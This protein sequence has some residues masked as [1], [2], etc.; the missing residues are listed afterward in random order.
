VFFPGIL[1]ALVGIILFIVGGAGNCSDGSNATEADSGGP[2]SGGGS[3][4]GGG[5][6]GGGTTNGSGGSGGGSLF[7]TTT[8]AAADEASDFDCTAFYAAGGSLLGLG[9]I[10]C[11]GGVVCGQ[12]DKRTGVTVCIFCASCGGGTLA[13][14]LRVRVRVCVCVRACVVCV[15]VRA[16]VR[17]CVCVCVC[18]GQRQREA[19]RVRESN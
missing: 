11:L 12:K 2:T 17:V 13:A 18:V 16:C 8:T 5:G 19:A 4:G 15:C 1:V 6:G 7:P 14:Q 10:G 9:V 3:G